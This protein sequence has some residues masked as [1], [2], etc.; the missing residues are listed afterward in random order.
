MGLYEIMCVKLFKLKKHYRTERLF[1]EKN[2]YIPEIYNLKDPVVIFVCVTLHVL[3][4][5]YLS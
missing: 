4:Q 5:L 1:I 2:V 3:I